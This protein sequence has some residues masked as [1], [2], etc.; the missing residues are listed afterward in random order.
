MTQSLIPADILGS[1]AAGLLIAGCGGSTASSS[2]AP[3]RHTVVA[4]SCAGL[5]P[6]KQFAMARVVFVGRMLPGPSTSLGRR[7]LLGSPASVRVLRYLKGGGP[8]TVR[9]TTALTITNRGVTEA[10]DGIEPQLGE[11]WKIYTDSR[12]QPFDTSICGGST[13]LASSVR[14]ALNLWSAFPVH[15]KPR[16]VV[17]LGEGVVLDPRTGF[18]DD[19]TKIAFE[20]GR[21][22]LGTA[23]PGSPGTV[24][25]DRISSPAGA[26]GLLRSEGRSSGIKV[27]PLIIRAVRLRAGTFLTDRGRRRLPAW[28]F[29]FKHVAKPASV[30]ALAPPDLFLPPPMQQLG[31]SGTGNSIEDSATADRPGRAIK[32][33]FIGAHAGNGPCDARYSAS[34]VSSSQAVA[35]TIKT[36]TTPAPPHTFCSDVGYTRTAVL[37]LREPLGARVLISSTDGGAVPVSR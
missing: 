9:V 37:H 32:I 31:P 15:A 28:Q 27:A 33:S 5:S 23:L 3:A 19:S 18:P 36:I 21:F 11:I 8:R 20:E 35:Y 7:D 14:V 6:A 26:Y 4:A 30:L 10:E 12:H 16:P 13:R 1:L 24:G 34:A 17:P 2:V 29:W 25:H 22:V